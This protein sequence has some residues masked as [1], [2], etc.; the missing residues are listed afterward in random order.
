ME[1]SHVGWGSAPQEQSDWEK[2]LVGVLKSVCLKWM[3]KLLALA[4]CSG[5]LARWSALKLWRLRGSPQ[6]AVPAFAI[7]L[8]I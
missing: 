8:T 5:L 4:F 1:R 2:P 3:Q 6:E 7:R